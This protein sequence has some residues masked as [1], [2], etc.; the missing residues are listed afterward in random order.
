M[1]EQEQQR[2]E[3]TVL[4]LDTSTASMAAA[5][6]R[7]GEIAGSVQSLAERNHSVLTVP[8]L[9]ALLDECGVEPE[10]LDGIAI[11]KGPGSYTGMRIAVTVGKT[12]AW[13]WQKPVVGISSLEALA[14]GARMAAAA[15]DPD[16]T[17]DWFIPI[18]DARRG[19]VYTA[20]F[21]ARPDGS[22]ERKAHDGIRLMRQWID[23]LAERLDDMG[24]GK[25]RLWL[26][27]DLSLH[28]QEA[29]R[30][31]ELAAQAASQNVAVSLFP[32]AM[33]GAAVARLGAERLLRGERDETHLFVPNYTQ[34]A[35]AE[36]KL[37]EKLAEGKGVERS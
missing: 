17:S 37:K 35:E 25:H 31:Q 34:L 12:L 20:L 13:A 24:A 11:G 4:A 9:K 27:G 2:A 21:A 26:T 18:M 6:L 22:W 16:C 10:E 15:H 32:F 19:Q 36:V 30:L 23:Q 33:E 29:A 8:K 1:R 7:G 28:E 3:P 5:L 14:Y